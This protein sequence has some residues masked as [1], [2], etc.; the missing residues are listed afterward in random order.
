VD[1]GI[2]LDPRPG[3]L[4]VIAIHAGGIELG[5]SEMARALADTTYSLYLFEGL[6]PS[7]NSVL[8]ITAANF[9]EP[10]GRA[11]VAGKD[12]CLSIHG[13]SGTV[14]AINVGG[15]DTA[16][17]DAIAA[18]LD[19]AGFNALV[20]GDPGFLSNYGGTGTQNICNTTT[21]GMGIQLEI[22][23]AQREAFFSDINSY[24]GRQVHTAAFDSFI[25]ALQAG[26]ATVIP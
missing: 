3:P 10:Q 12:Y 1:Y 23:R 25:T 14:A 22:T 20:P 16:L 7:G 4:A 24:S 26:I 18:A 17:R 5:A 11:L 13:C 2:V 15:R 21:R 9:D 19:A 6:K 8:H